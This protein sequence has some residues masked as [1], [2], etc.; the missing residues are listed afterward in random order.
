MCKF[1]M[2]L[3][4]MQSRFDMMNDKHMLQANTQGHQG[5]CG[6]GIHRMMGQMCQG[7]WKIFNLEDRVKYKLQIKHIENNFVGA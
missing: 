3:I 1:T 5:E 6:G 4:R 2:A 7:Q